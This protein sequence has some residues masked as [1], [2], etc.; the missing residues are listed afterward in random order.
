[1]LSFSLINETSPYYLEP[2][3]MVDVN[4]YVP[5]TDTDKP[6]FLGKYLTHDQPASDDAPPAEDNK[7]VRDELGDVRFNKDGEPLEKS[8]VGIRGFMKRLVGKPNYDQPQNDDG[9]IIEPQAA[10]SGNRKFPKLLNYNK[11]PPEEQLW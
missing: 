6:S 5:E 9:K 11:I 8:D 7:Y 1:M 10:F 2:T 3:E 4:G